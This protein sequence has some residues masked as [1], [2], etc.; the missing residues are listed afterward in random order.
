MRRYWTGLSLFVFCIVVTSVL[1]GYV[2]CPKCGWENAEGSRYCSHCGEKLTGET[3][4]AAVVA[5]DPEESGDVDE[6]AYAVSSE[7]VES[8]LKTAREYLEAGDSWLAFF[9]CD[10]AMALN[11]LAPPSEER[12]DRVLQIH[13]LSGRQARTSGRMCTKCNGTGKISKSVSSPSLG[14][15]TRTYQ[16]PAKTCPACKGKGII[17]GKST[18]EQLRYDYGTSK[19]RYGVLRHGK[20]WEPVGEAWVPPGVVQGLNAREI[21]TLKRVT[22]SRCPFCLGFGRI[23]CE[24]CGGTGETDCPNCEDGTVVKELE[25]SIREDAKRELRTKC[26]GTGKIKCL[27]CGGRKNVLC[28]TCSG[29]GKRPKCTKCDGSGLKSCRKCHGSG[30]YR[31]E[32][33]PLC[34]SCGVLLCTTC[35]G[36][37]RAKPRKSTRK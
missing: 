9:Y 27:T 7:I 22:G 10:N 17:P 13:D 11:M 2:I 21:A 31:G 12:S 29:D 14:G 24:A 32:T 33:C 20:R 34:R 15:G 6:S 36:D 4:A 8:E 26:H 1:A 25:E 5:E 28:D 16:L 19:Q 18:L 23:T 37:G 35:Q 30:I 3:N